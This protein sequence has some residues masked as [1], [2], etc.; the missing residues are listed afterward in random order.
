MNAVT[1][2]Q[3][4]KSADRHARAG[5]FDAAIT[6]Y[7]KVSAADPDDLTVA[8]TLGDLY[9]RQG[10]KGEAIRHF[11]RIADRFNTDGFQVKAI[12]MYKK[13]AKI[14][15]E[16][17]DL[18]VQ[19]ADLYAR[20]NLLGEAK[21]QF[22]AVADGY[23]RRGLPREAL[24]VLKRAADVDPSNLKARVG[25]AEGY[26]HEGFRNEASDA[27]RA[28][29]QEM[30][31]SGKTADAVAA[32]TKALEL[33]PESRSALKLLA[34]AHASSGDVSPALDVI[35]RAL[36]ADP[37]DIDL[38]II[39]GRTF[40]NAGMLEKA[41]STFERLFSLDNSRY[42][43]LL[44]VGR[45][46]VERGE[47]E[48]TLAIVDSCIEVLLARRHKKKATAL[49]K[50]ILEREP[51]HVLTLK[52]LA[53][54]Y[55]SVRERRNLVNAL[56]TLVQAALAQDLRAEAAAALRQLVE[57]E[58][59]KAVYQE[60]LASLHGEDGQGPIG[61][62]GD[63]D[64]ETGLALWAG[65][66]EPPP[67]DIYES[68]GDYSTELLEEMVAQHPEFMQARLKLLEEL[69]AQQPAYVE[70]RQKLKQLYVESGNRAKA[71]SQC[72]ELAR[73]YDQAGDPPSAKQYLAEAFALNPELKRP[74]GGLSAAV[75]EAA[76]ASRTAEPSPSEPVAPPAGPPPVRL[77]Q[78]VGVEEFEKLFEREWRRTA[79]EPKPISILKVSVDRFESYDAGEGAVRSLECLERVA[80]VLES[81]LDRAGQLVA[82][83][84]AEYFFVLLPETHPGTAGTIADGM[85]RGVEAL[86][87]AHPNGT[88]MTISVGAATAFPY[89]MTE[90]DA[91]VESIDKALETARHRGGNRVVTVP[92][93]GA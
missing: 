82:S 11:M 63:G 33:K 27:Y 51:R 13:I 84:G 32:F 61:A 46:Y 69:V 81:E 78:M 66:A 54:I 59:K 92:L 55:K 53:G 68:Y 52:R 30:M 70:G 48:R 58:P 38:I 76:E 5:N 36:E 57:I 9:A 1:K 16:N 86:D 44:E 62:D 43:Y 19:L 60:Q 7:R 50:A 42:D 31:R 41:E 21:Q 6:E 56:N 90:P 23:R 35:A 4:L 14:D 85:R 40:L 75:A 34:E 73:H 83:S 79:R 20:Q 88:T 28:A 37:N 10:L 24:K 17:L 72:L 2:D 80:G 74:S 8:N 64:F 87:I 71:A 91:L 65:E 93:L 25:L 3:M 77:S 49:L 26:A 89:R 67:D 39:L 15:P 45:A 12:A 29:G 22:A 47:F 18:G